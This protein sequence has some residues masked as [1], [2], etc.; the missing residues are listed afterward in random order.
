ML[1]DIVTE[2][3][4]LLCCLLALPTQLLWQGKAFGNGLVLVSCGGGARAE[5]AQG[6]R[7]SDSF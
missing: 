4:H 1:N 7:S 3:F 6:F 5:E 2:D